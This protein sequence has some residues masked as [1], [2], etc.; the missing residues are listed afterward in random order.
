MF[1]DEY[2]DEIFT[3]RMYRAI[4]EEAREDGHKAGWEDGHKAGWEDGHKEG[5]TE[6][7]KDG[8][9]EGRTEAL[10]QINHLN[11]SLIRDGRQED[12]LKS[13]SDPDF[14]KELLKEYGLLDQDSSQTT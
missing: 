9:K 7:R 14:Q 1:L 8:R 3:K 11:Q 6:G 12:L 10:E 2:D 13:F 4:A 5:H